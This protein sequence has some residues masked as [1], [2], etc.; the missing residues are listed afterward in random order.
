MNENM[1]NISI[2]PQAAYAPINV[3]P[4]GGGGGGGGGQRGGFWQI[5]K[6]F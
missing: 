1:N 6:F 3:K 5:L 4:V 2:E